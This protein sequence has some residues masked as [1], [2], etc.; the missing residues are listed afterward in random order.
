M[1]RFLTHFRI[2]PFT[3][4]FANDVNTCLSIIR[5]YRTPFMSL[6]L[7]PFCAHQIDS[8]K[9]VKAF[10]ALALS[11]QRSGSCGINQVVSNTLAAIFTATGQ[12]IACVHESSWSVF[13]ISAEEEIK[14]QSTEHRKRRGLSLYSFDHKQPV[15]T[16]ISNTQFFDQHW[17]VD[18][19]TKWCTFLI[20]LRW[21]PTFVILGNA[22]MKSEAGIYA[23]LVL[24][25]LLIGT[26]GG[27]T[28]TPTAKE[29]LNMLGCLGKVIR[30]LLTFLS[31]AF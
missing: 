17:T 19:I 29:S 12:D 3:D 30:R 22:G 16:F 2:W 23:C 4:L 1:M 18:P 5:A 13:E 27:G 25:T 11:A 31:H 15:N 6:S 7:I 21:R 20:W 14:I 24:P 8:K 28:Y 26:V 10:N 9:L